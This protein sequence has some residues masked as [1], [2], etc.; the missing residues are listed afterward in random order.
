[1]FETKSSS[2]IQRRPR[3]RHLAI[4]AFLAVTAAAIPAL[5]RAEP[6]LPGAIFTTNSACQRV[7]QNIYSFKQDVFLDGGP[8]HSQSASLPDGSYYVQVTSPQGT[9]LGTSVGTPTPMPFVVTNGSV[10][11]LQ[12]WSIVVK[13]SGPTQGYDTTD[14]SGGEYKVWISDDPTFIDSSTKTD[15]FKVLGEDTEP[16]PFSLGGQKFY[17]ANTNGAKDA[18]EVGI[19]GWR[20]NLFGDA[21]SSTTT[22]A[23]GNYE[24]LVNPGSYGV[25]EVIPSAAPVWVNTTPKVLNPASG[26]NNNFGNVC[27]GSGGGLTLGFWSNKNGQ[28]ILTGSK[29]GA[30]INQTATVPVLGQ[31]TYLGLLNFLNLKNANGTDFVL[32]ATN[33][34][35]AFRTW[36]LGANAT[37]MAYMLS[38][39]LAT[40]ALNVAS[41]GVD[42]NALI[43][44]P[45]SQSA[46]PAG[47]AT[48]NAI[49]AEANTELGAHGL[50][51]AASP[52]RA[53]QE[54]LK[55]YLD[56]ANNNSNFVQPNACDVNYVVSDTCNGL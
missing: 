10:D 47:F 22:D 40:M 17:D 31:T 4:A 51:L 35:T 38:A 23:Q 55:N 30:T 46:N 20:I 36:I 8:Q 7:D 9:L 54:A 16:L 6:P 11:C 12:L 44:A 27:L 56:Q 14:N 28:N 3:V 2:M 48:I 24:F 50:V 18:N 53:Y 37:N 15:N 52:Y 41:G 26:T 39:Q 25:C 49:I 13:A 45:N 5:L 43:Y 33:N 34:Y 42:G 1:M 32:A 19:P 21:T 29:T